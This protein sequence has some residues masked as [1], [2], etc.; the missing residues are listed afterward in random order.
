VWFV[1]IVGSVL[2]LSFMWLFVIDN[3]RLHDLL[4]T[5]LAALL[6]LLVFLLAAMDLP[7]RGDY[8]VGPDSF[9][10]VYDQLMTK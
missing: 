8:S 2:N 1:V 9:E 7:F 5:I 6:G 3:K 4:T 10:L